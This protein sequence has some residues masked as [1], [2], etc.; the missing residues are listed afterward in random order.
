MKVFVDSNVLIYTKD[1][2]NPSKRAAAESW[3]EQLSHRGAIV[4]SR[5]T[6]REYYRVASSAKVG[7]PREKLQSDIRAL[8]AWLPLDGGWDHLEDAW[9]IEQQF[10]L[11]FYDSLLLASARA[12]GCAYF[13]TEDLHDGLD[14]LGTRV[15]HFMRVDAGAIFGA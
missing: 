3:L 13:L 6:L 8:H 9:T 1:R 5:Q 4:V 11:G 2:A 12:A 14:V 15:I 10:K 7:A